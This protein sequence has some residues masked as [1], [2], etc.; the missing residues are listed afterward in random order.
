V[1][2]RR[3]V[4]LLGVV[5]G[6][7]AWYVRSRREQATS[8]FTPRPPVPSQQ[9]SPAP[10]PTQ[11]PVPAAPVSDGAGPGPAEP[12]DG[13]VEPG[14]AA[15][16]DGGVEPGPY[17]GSALPLGDGGSPAPSFVIKGNEDSMLYHEPEGRYFEATE[18]EVWFE[19][20]ADAEAAGF[21]RPGFE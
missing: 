17:E 14:P 5:G 9:P 7:V 6:G 20:S 21:A 13:G 15:L 16:L 1:S 2:R 19:T 4:L 3:T 18:A 8:A 11:P 10:R 12:L